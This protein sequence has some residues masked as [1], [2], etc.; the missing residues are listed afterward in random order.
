MPLNKKQKDLVFA[1]GLASFFCFGIAAYLFW[2]MYPPGTLYHSG[3][4][5]GRSSSSYLTTW[6]SILTAV[7]P[8]LVIGI[9]TFVPAALCF[10]KNRNNID[11]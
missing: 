11:E 9:I 1:L 10:V 7:V 5:K 3:G 8:F 2:N 6:Q 4:Y